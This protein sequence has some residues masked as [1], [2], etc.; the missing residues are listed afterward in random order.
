MTGCAVGDTEEYRSSPKD[1]L[2]L[3][4]SDLAITHPW[5][6]EHGIDTC[7]RNKVWAM[8]WILAGFV[9]SSTLTCINARQ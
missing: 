3:G 2:E 9:L 4:L 8:G 5:S 6:I 7:K 1:A